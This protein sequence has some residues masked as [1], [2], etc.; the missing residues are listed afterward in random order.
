MFAPAA[1]DMKDLREYRRTEVRRA[2]TAAKHTLVVSTP[3]PKGIADAFEN[4][5][6][7]G[8]DAIG[9]SGVQELL[10]RSYGTVPDGNMIVLGMGETAT[11]VTP[12]QVN[13]GVG[14]YM[15]SMLRAIAACTDL[16]F[17]EAFRLYAKL[18]Y[19]NART[20]RLIS[21]A[22]YR[23]WRDS[24]ED[25]I[26]SPTWELLVRY[27]WANG[28]LGNIAWTP[29]LLAHEWHWDEMEWVDPAK[30]VGAN[31]EAMATD[32]KSLVEICAER[33]RDWKQVLRENLEVESEEARIRAELGLPA[34]MSSAPSMP[35]KEN[36]EEP[37]NV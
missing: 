18:N 22:V 21:K 8:T 9:A 7:D 24:L 30:E 31:A 2:Q 20:I 4:L 15:E 26:C 12:P 3:D 1:L 10:G 28:L 27:W 33:G 25:A 5:T 11:T 14:D 16:P 36:L 17:E 35:A 6:L 23:D 19:S 29:D 32:Q 34:K 37:E 13:S